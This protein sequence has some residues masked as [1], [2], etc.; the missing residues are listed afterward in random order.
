VQEKTVKLS[1]AD[2]PRPV[3]AQTQKPKWMQRVIHQSPPKYDGKEDASHVKQQVEEEHTENDEAKIDEPSQKEKKKPTK[4]QQKMFWQPQP[5]DVATKQDAQP[6]EENKKPRWQEL[7]FYIVGF[8]ECGTTT[9]HHVLATMHEGTTMKEVEECHLGRSKLVL[10]EMARRKI[11]KDLYTL[12][13]D[14]TLRRGI[15]CSFGLKHRSAVTRTEKYFPESKL[16]VGVRHPVDFLESFYNY[17][18]T[19]ANHHAKEKDDNVPPPLETLI[20]DDVEWKNINT[21]AARFE[22]NLGYL[23]K[24]NNTD[25]YYPPTKFK[26]F[27]YT[28]EQMNDTNEKRQEMFRSELQEFLELKQPIPPLNENQPANKGD[29]TVDICDSKYDG[30]REELISKGTTT[31]NWILKEFLLSPD[32]TVGNFNHFRTLLQQWGTDPC[33]ARTKKT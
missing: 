23:G 6:Q 27:L 28:F 12:S 10:P 1:L 11:N 13:K 26:V 19:Q 9:L 33:S 17:R 7:D 25:K 8:P 18:V 29:G 32:V 20:E 24:T 21:L 4:A 30:L 3:K 31:Q 15:K 16:I 5:Q 14:D 22:T 2:F